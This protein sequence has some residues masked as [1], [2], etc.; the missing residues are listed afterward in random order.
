MADRGKKRERW[1]TKTL[2]YILHQPQKQWL[3]EGKRGEDG[4]TKILIS[5]EWKKLFRWNKKHFS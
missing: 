5:L 2:R 3:T 4:N 1:N